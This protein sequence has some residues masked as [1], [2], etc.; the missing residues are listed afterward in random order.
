MIETLLA[1]AAL[2][3][4]LAVAHLHWLVLFQ[5]GAALVAAGMALGV[6]AGL[7]YH[8][9]L[10][11]GLLRSGDLPALWWVHPVHHHP[12]LDERGLRAIRPSF[13]AGAAGFGVAAL[14]CLVAGLGAL[15][16]LG[17]L[18]PG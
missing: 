5:L 14:G 15:G 1:L 3:A 2:G 9:R 7:L 11:E 18:Q 16:A 4:L 6:P 13:Y 10:R 12:R 8:L 17:W